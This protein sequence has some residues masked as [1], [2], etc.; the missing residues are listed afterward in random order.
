[1][2]ILTVGTNVLSTTVYAQNMKLS[3]PPICGNAL[4][5]LVGLD[6]TAIKQFAKTTVTITDYV[7]NLDNANVTTDIR[8]KLVLQTVTVVI[9]ECAT[10]ATL[11]VAS[12][13]KALFIPIKN[14]NASSTANAGTPHRS[15]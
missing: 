3:V 14:K 5:S 4:V 6:T 11:L 12:A 13:I 10:L 7:R 8:E 1:M 9:E 2:I 15:V